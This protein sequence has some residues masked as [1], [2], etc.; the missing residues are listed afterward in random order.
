MKR[1][2]IIAHIDKVGGC[3]AGADIDGMAKVVKPSKNE[4]TAL[5]IGI[6]LGLAFAQIMLEDD[7][8]TPRETVVDAV[9]LFST[10]MTEYTNLIAEA[11]DD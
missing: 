5:K 11:A 6:S 9:D 2:E 4:L 8:A 10:A 3:I 7:E 1:K